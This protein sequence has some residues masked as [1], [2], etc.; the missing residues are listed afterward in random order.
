MTVQLGDSR[1]SSGGGFGADNLIVGIRVAKEQL[2]VE[3]SE[4]ATVLV[5]RASTNRSSAHN[6]W[7]TFRVTATTGTGLLLRNWGSYGPDGQPL[8]APNEDDG[9]R[10]AP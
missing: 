10:P 8:C 5:R 4:G 1:G 9:S 2:F 6:G 7:T 3:V